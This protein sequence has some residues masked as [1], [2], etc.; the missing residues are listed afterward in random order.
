MTK[1]KKKKKKL[2][3]DRSTWLVLYTKHFDIYDMNSI[4]QDNK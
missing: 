2:N 4:V 1:K 3:C